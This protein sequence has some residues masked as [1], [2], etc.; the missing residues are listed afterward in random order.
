MLPTPIREQRGGGPG[1]GSALRSRP[2]RPPPAA[3]PSFPPHPISPAPRHLQS[4][5]QPCPQA[6][7]LTVTDP[8]GGAAWALGSPG[9]L[10]SGPAVAGEAVSVPGA[11]SCRPGSP[12][13]AWSRWALR[14]PVRSAKGQSQGYGGPVPSSAR[15]WGSWAGGRTLGVLGPAAARPAERSLQTEPGRTSA[16]R[17]TTQPFE[18]SGANPDGAP[19]S[20][21]R[22]LH[23]RRDRRGSLRCQATCEHLSRGAPLSWGAS[24]GC[25]TVRE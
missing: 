15:P 20:R 12:H 11:N 21:H 22:P 3:P 8:P 14:G 7:A 23:F 18:A 9:P 6:S 17:H 5:P 2:C 1:Q 16:T 25:W 19:W 4:P 13:L 24:D 10:V